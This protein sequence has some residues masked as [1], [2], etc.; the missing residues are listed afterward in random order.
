[1][2][3]TSADVALPIAR[4]VGLPRDP[5]TLVRLNAGVQIGVGAVLAAGFVPRLASL[6]LGASLV[7]TT[8]AGHRFWAEQEPP[9]RDVQL[10]QFAKNAGVLGGLLAAA[11]DTGGRP[12]L[13][14]SGRRAAGHVAQ[15]VADTATAAYHTIP[16]VS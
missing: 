4:A 9:K 1:M 14:W 6:V 7:P 12:S 15:S 13:F 16:G 8:I 5:V 11:L 10:I 2:A 3:D